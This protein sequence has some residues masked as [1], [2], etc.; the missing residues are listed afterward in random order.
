[1]GY[2]RAAPFAA[3]LSIAW[4]PSLNPLWPL[5]LSEVGHQPAFFSRRW[6]VGAM[7]NPSIR[8]LLKGQRG[9]WEPGSGRLACLGKPMAMPV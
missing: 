8:V 9:L 2:R 7:V 3:R 4:R 6:F 5:R 1:M